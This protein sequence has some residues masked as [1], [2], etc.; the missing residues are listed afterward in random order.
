MR[1][2]H[3]ER[4]IGMKLLAHLREMASEQVLIGTWTEAA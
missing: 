4:G 1:C 3:Q 2:V